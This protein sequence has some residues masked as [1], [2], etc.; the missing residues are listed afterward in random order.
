MFTSGHKEVGYYRNLTELKKCRPIN[1]G[2]IPDLPYFAFLRRNDYKL[3]FVSLLW[4]IKRQEI[5]RNHLL[6]RKSESSLHF[7]RDKLYLP[8]IYNYLSDS[9]HL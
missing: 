1:T 3:F 7:P 6:I 8:R 5:L 2:I 9:C 4:V